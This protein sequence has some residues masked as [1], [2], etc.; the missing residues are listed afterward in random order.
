[1]GRR[2]SILPCSLVRQQPH[3]VVECGAASQP[4]F[5]KAVLLAADGKP[6][7]A[8]AV[9]REVISVGA[10]LM[11]D[12]RRQIDFRFGTGRVRRASEVLRV[13]LAR[14]G[15]ASDFAAVGEGPAA[16]DF[17]SA[18]R[19]GGQA[20]D[21]DSAASFLRDVANGR[22]FLAHRFAALN[23]LRMAHCGAPVRA[24]FKEDSADVAAFRAVERTL[25]RESDRALLAWVRDTVGRPV[26]SPESASDTSRNGLPP[27]IGGLS[28]W[29]TTSVSSAG[30]A[31]VGR[32]P[33]SM[34]VHHSGNDAGSIVPA[35][36]P[37]G[38]FT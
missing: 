28:R 12:G 14:S 24:L 2:C 20:K 34:E 31:A 5:A 6:D 15:E 17:L 9:L 8:A 25:R 13:L 36:P 30:R 7:S 1:M 11:E 35:F 16:S 26:P 38:N 4:R 37:L 23:G 21:L 10:L 27:G 3:A 22:D 19:R 29:D 18:S 33:W 32:A